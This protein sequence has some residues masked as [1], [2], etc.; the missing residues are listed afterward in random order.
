MGSICETAGG[1]WENCPF[2]YFS[3]SPEESVVHSPWTLCSF[4]IGSYIS[5][6]GKCFHQATSK[7]PA[8]LC[9]K[10]A[11]Q[12]AW[13][14]PARATAGRI[15]FMVL[16]G[17]LTWI[18]NVAMQSDFCLCS[19]L[20]VGVSPLPLQVLILRAISNKL[21]ACLPLSQNS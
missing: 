14:P 15:K 13:A 9:P 11:T 20:L 5:Q 16:G 2:H 7:R 10:T 17:Q 3:D 6:R 21:S 12:V 18:I 19:I 8:K 1:S 4:W